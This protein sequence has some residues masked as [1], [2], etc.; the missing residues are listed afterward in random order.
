MAQGRPQL[1]L[2]LAVEEVVRL[3]FVVV[4]G[5]PMKVIQAVTALGVPADS[6][7]GDG[8]LHSRSNWGVTCF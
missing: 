7:G 6:G 8:D 1:H 3:V 5:G 4:T 2:L